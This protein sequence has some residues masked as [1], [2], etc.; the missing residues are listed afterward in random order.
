M[1]QSPRLEVE[2]LCFEPGF[3]GPEQQGREASRW[4]C[5]PIRLKRL[6]LHQKI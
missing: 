5:F 1:I 6:Y 2:G 3:G 4:T